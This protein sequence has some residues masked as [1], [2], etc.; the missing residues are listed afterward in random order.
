MKAH[1]NRSALRRLKEARALD[2]EIRDLARKHNQDEMRLAC[3]LR[4]MKEKNFTSALGFESVF[5]YAATR[6]G[7]GRDKTRQLMALAGR[8]EELPG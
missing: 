1:T 5:A 3:L 6:L 4:D 8:F 7:Y 2:G